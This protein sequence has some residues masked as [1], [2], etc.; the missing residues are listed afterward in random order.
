[1]G[2]ELRWAVGRRMGK[3]SVLTVCLPSPP[4][5]SIKEKNISIYNIDSFD[6]QDLSPSLSPLET[7]TE[8]GRG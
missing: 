3:R 8:W 2:L 1:M 6:F 5:V 4:S 7:V